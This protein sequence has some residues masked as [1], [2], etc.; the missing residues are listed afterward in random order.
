MDTVAQLVARGRIRFPCV[1]DP[2]ERSDDTT[3]VPI[4]PGSG[5]G[6]RTVRVLR[7]DLRT[8]TWRYQD[9]L[10]DDQLLGGRALTAAI[11]SGEVPPDCDPLGQDNQLILAA[12]ALAGLGVSSAGR[13]S[14][15]AK[16]PLTGGIKE[17]NAGG[18]GADALAGLGLRAVVLEG[19]P[20]AGEWEILVIDD[21]GCRFLDANP[22]LGLGNFALVSRLFSDFGPHYAVISIGQ[23]GEQRLRAAAVAVTDTTGRPSRMAA[24][25]GLGAVMGAKGLKAILISRVPASLRQRGG[26]RA[27]ASGGSRQFGRPTPVDREAFA[28]ARK[29]FHQT[30]MGN[31][32]IQVLT[33]YGT[34]STTMLTNSLGALPTRS[35]TCG[36][37]EGAEA[38][39]GENIYAVIT[40]RGGAGTP[41]ETCMPGCLIRC[42]NVF[43]G[44][45]GREL[46]APLEY[47]TLGMMGSNLGL[48][49]L[50]AIAELN[51]LCNDYGLDTIET[52]AALGVMAEKGLVGFGDA[53][54]FLR[55]VREVASG[56][57]WGRLLGMGTVA[58]GERLGA[59]RVPV[60]R[61]QAISAYDPRGVKGTGVTYATSP[62]GGDHTAG[63]T[64]F[65][66][67]DHHR[68]EGQV[69]LSANM[70]VGRAA[71]DALGLCVFL[72]GATATQPRLVIDMLNAAYGVNLPDDYL[73]VLGERVLS[74]E[75]A[76]NEKAGI[77]WGPALAGFFWQEKLGPDGLVFDVPA[78]E[79]EQALARFREVTPLELTGCR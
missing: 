27:P 75:L 4:Y 17:A 19:Q 2:W 54:G 39:S 9:L 3:I 33:K 18:T 36:T 40:A 63:L 32:R 22:Y 62:M 74:T 25:G 26:S 15:G 41:T 46:V 43:P 45:D 20:R 24:R 49:S 30:V 6:G 71:Y 64:V 79:M 72:M 23:A 61:G 52:G 57:E 66:P 69:V 48:D 58:V 47:E 29:R 12:G 38:L 37:F 51:F 76:F 50:D 77:G 10:P 53:A 60:A 67:V 65:A 13:L 5:S 78:A 73:R 16:S 14:L 42:S 8:R 7:V 70:Q 59:V 31:E 34:A 56:G 35:F 1:E 28:E 44:A 21:Q 68:A 55:M 11:V